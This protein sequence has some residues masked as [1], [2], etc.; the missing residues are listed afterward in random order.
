MVLARYYFPE[1]NVDNLVAATKVF[2]RSHWNSD[3]LGETPE[4]SE[5]YE[6]VG[7]IPNNIKQGIYAFLAKNKVHYVGVAAS[8]NSGRYDGA[9]IGARVTQYL[10]LASEQP[11][12]PVA[13]RRY[14]LAKNW[15]EVD[16]LITL[17]FNR[18][19]A[20]L[21]YGLEVFLISMLRPPANK[22]RTGQ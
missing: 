16:G 15:P 6:F 12:V 2:F 10:R 4:W 11:K 7:T 19:H 21:A 9:G 22:I 18:E 13:E 20:Y 8:R 3:E 1:S 5:R 14:K 17:G